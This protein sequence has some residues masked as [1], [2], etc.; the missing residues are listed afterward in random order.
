MYKNDKFTIEKQVYDFTATD[1][2][3]NNI[4]LTITGN[5]SLILVEELSYI[6]LIK[7][8]TSTKTHSHAVISLFILNIY[9]I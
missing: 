8:L 4:L 9:Y 1:T 6:I 5:T 7:L 3:I 2:A